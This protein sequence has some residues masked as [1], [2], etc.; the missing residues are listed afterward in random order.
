MLI[1]SGKWADG[2]S[3][4]IDIPLSWT[5]VN[6]SSQHFRITNARGTMFLVG[7][8]RYARIGPGSKRDPWASQ[9]L[10]EQDEWAYTSTK[11]DY[12]VGCVNF[13]ES[14]SY[15][16]TEP[17]IARIEWGLLKGF[18]YRAN[19]SE[20][21]KVAGFLYAENSWNVYIKLECSADVLNEEETVARNVVSA[22]RF[23]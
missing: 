12:E 9:N 20:R 13:F 22:I 11:G 1:E 6:Q 3:W 2:T 7:F 18:V 14:F 8:S 4:K 23:L 15:L 10:S 5:V 17:D 16:F 19:A 21:S